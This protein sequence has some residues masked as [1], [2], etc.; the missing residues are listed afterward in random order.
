MWYIQRQGLCIFTTISVTPTVVSVPP[1]EDQEEKCRSFIEL[2]PGETQGRYN[3]NQTRE[4][5]KYNLYSS[6]EPSLPSSDLLTVSSVLLAHYY[7]TKLVFFQVSSGC[8]S[9][10]SSRTSAFWLWA[11]CWCVWKHFASVPR[12]RW[13]P[14]R[15]TPSLPC[16]PSC[17][18]RMSDT[19]CWVV[20]K[21]HTV[22]CSTLNTGSPKYLWDD[23]RMMSINVMSVD[24][25]QFLCIWIC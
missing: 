1:G 8:Q 15:S 25:Y 17:Q 20:M 14:S 23:V 19:L 16:A 6:L 13:T 12:G 11:S 21:W 5:W 9:S 24:W 2:T 18:V 22:I 10:V 4:L 7:P 3:T